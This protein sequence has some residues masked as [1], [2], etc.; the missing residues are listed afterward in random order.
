MRLG[1]SRGQV[2]IFDVHTHENYQSRPYL[3]K[4]TFGTCGGLLEDLKRPYQCIL[5][6][7]GYSDSI[8]CVSSSIYRPL[9]LLKHPFIYLSAY[10][11]SYLP[12]SPVY[13]AS[14]A[15]PASPVSPVSCSLF[16]DP[17]MHLS[18][19]LSDRVFSLIESN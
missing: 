8:G 19:H 11:H 4:P 15:S 17:T 16:N 14:P 10:L 2:S 6:R 13:P 5:R 9:F 1:Y 12:V 18:I 7:S 3:D